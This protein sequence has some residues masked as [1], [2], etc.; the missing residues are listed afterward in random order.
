MIGREANHTYDKQR[1]FELQTRNIHATTFAI[2]DMRGDLENLERH[3]F[4]VEA[5]TKLLLLLKVSVS[6]RRP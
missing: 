2:A 6:S 3:S 4:Q 1:E 5:V